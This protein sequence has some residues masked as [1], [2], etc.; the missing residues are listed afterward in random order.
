MDQIDYDDF[1]GTELD[2][3]DADRQ[4]RMDAVESDCTVP[5]TAVCP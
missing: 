5:I 4:K 1:G 2:L 3:I